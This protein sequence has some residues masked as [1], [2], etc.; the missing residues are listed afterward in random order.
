MESQSFALHTGMVISAEGIAIN[1]VEG[2][3]LMASPGGGSSKIYG[4]D[5]KAITTDVPE[6]EERLIY[7]NLDLNR[8]VVA[9][10]LIDC[11]GQYSRPDILS[12]TVNTGA[13]PHIRYTDGSS[14]NENQH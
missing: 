8:C 14:D 6:T 1:E 12:L 2:S 5:G 4:P 13:R 7:A 3:Y 9:N 10:G 11:I